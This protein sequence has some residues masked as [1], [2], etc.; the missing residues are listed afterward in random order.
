M[1]ENSEIIIPKNKTLSRRAFLKVGLVALGALPILPFSSKVEA[2]D[3]EPDSFL[4]EKLYELKGSTIDFLGVAHSVE[5][6]AEYGNLIHERVK[7]LM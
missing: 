4:V 6:F 5:T 1:S 7:K 2:S 3:K